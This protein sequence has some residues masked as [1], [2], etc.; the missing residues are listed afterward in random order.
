MTG[1]YRRAM[2]IRSIVLSTMVAAIVLAGCD[3]LTGPGGAPYP[4]SC[5]SFEFSERRCAA[6]VARARHT[7]AGQVASEPVGI[8]LLHSEDGSAQLG[9]YQVARVVFTLSD[10]TRVVEP[11]M[12]IGVPDGPG[13]RSARSRSSGSRATRAT[14]SRA[15]ATPPE[16]CATPIALD[17]AAVAA[18]RP[19]QLAT[20][21]VPLD[22]VGHHEV[23]VGDVGLPNGY[24]TA[25]RAAVGDTHPTDFWLDE[26]IRLELRPSDPSRPPFGSVYERG[27]VEGVEDASLWLVFDVTEVSP[28]AVLRLTDIDV[29]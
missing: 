9:G 26:P 14:M 3:A 10:G 17:P 23:K 29:R 24:V 15:P 18:A 11:V 20:F 27:T 19:L 1:C 28:G 25:L 5:G 6:I 4:A 7:A 13:M 16:V 12:C 2:H 8:G 21:D 22:Q